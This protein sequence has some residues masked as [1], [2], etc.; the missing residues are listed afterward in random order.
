MWGAVAGAGGGRLG[1][2]RASGPGEDLAVCARALIADWPALTQD[3][4]DR[5]ALVLRSGR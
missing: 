5:V 3:Q 4:L 1:A 2:S